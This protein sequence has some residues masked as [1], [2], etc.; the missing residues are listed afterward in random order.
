MNLTNDVSAART[1]KRMRVIYVIEA[2]LEYFVAL[3][4]SNTYLPR[5]CDE[6]GVSDAFK[7]VI[8]GIGTIGCSAQ[9]LT[10]LVYNKA[11]FKIWITIAQTVAHLFYASLW[12]V[13]SLRTPETVKLI[14]FVA[15]MLFATTLQN[16][17]YAPKA[18][19][20]MSFVDE[21]KR[22]RF[23]AVKEIV[24]L[25]GGILFTLAFGKVADGDGEQAFALCGVITLA[26]GVLHTI[27]LAVL[28]E[29]P[30]V[31]LP[32]EKGIFRRL[33]S[34]K[35]FLK[36]QFLGIMWYATI[37][38]FVPLFAT[39][40]YAAY[41]LNMSVFAVSVITACGKLVQALLSQP[42]GRLADKT[43]FSKMLNASFFIE[44]G[45]L[46]FAALAF[47]FSHGYGVAMCAGFW[48][49]YYAGYAGINSV[50]FNIM[51][52]YVEPKER[53]AAI[54]LSS[55]ARGLCAFAVT[56]AVSMLASLIRSAGIAP[57]GFRAD[58]VHVFAIAAIIMTAFAALYNRNAIRKLKRAKYS[59]FEQENETGADEKEQY[60]CSETDFPETSVNE[61]KDE[62]ENPGGQKTV[63]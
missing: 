38:S 34:N 2:M 61:E 17:V 55:A 35:A 36:V 3:G 43:S 11:P 52:D 22:G 40:Q 27:S 48:V 42:L 41:G 59:A 31:K 21:D 23:T 16:V 44:I 15:F 60:V 32:H 53:T 14:A 19:W 7:P 50:F 18:A 46:C 28:H 12:F 54:A 58:G 37:E 10:L 13:P 62:G 1:D 33:M 47:P 25:I 29:K 57:G 30:Y 51:F 5:L 4:V 56:F 26:S 49:L 63:P 9:L 45:A 20:M 24:S 6:I 8:I 39:Y